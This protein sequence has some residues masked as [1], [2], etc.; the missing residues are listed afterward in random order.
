LAGFLKPGPLAL[1]RGPQ[2]PMRCPWSLKVRPA[3]PKPGS[4]S[5]LV[6]GTGGM[7]SSGGVLVRCP[8]SFK[9]RPACPN[10]GSRIRVSQGT[11]GLH[12]CLCASVVGGVGYTCMAGAFLGQP[13]SDLRKEALGGKG[14]SWQ[15]FRC[16]LGDGAGLCQ[17][18]Y[19][20]PPLVVLMGQQELPLKLRFLPQN[21]HIAAASWPPNKRVG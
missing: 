4:Q 12:H 16:P 18:L 21:L 20:E 10:P 17:Q 2:T 11:S 13:L 19:G 9:D 6:E 5:P 1:T 8:R 3:C 15:M 7:S 14:G